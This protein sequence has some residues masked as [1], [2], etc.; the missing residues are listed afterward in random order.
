M[1]KNLLLQQNRELFDKLQF[2]M[3]SNK[4]LK[5]EN[6][7]LTEKVQILSHQLQKL[8]ERIDS[9]EAVSAVSNPPFEADIDEPQGTQTAAEEI[10]LPPETEYGSNAI[11]EIVMQSVFFSNR[12]NELNRPNL[13]ELLNLILGKTEVAKAE[14]LNIVLSNADLENK[15]SMIDTVKAEA[16]EYFQS[17]LA[18]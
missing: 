5:Q 12:L 14:I 8:S 4:R 2:A 16:I 11:G 17:V 15:F 10:V 3:L 18:Q 9:L 13:K 6:T 7:Q 1:N